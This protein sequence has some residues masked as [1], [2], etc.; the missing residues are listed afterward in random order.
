MDIENQLEAAL[1]VQDPG[2]AFTQAVL[3]RVNARVV[4]VHGAGRWRL[5]LSLAASVVLACLGAL[6]VKQDM[7]QQRV[8]QTREQLLLALAITS[9]ELNDIHQKLSP[10]PLQENGI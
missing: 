10:E 7:Q 5:P 6:L 2:P 3:A 1:R 4:P 9:A 8:A